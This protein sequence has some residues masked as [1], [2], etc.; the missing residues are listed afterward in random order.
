MPAAHDNYEI[1]KEAAQKYFLNFD[2]QSIIDI[3]H[4]QNDTQYLYVSFFETPYR[5]NRKNGAIEKSTD[6][7]VTA[8]AAGFQEVLSIFD[9][10]CHSR[11]R[12]QPSGNWAPVNSLKGRPRT[13]GV[14]TGLYESSSRIF[15]ADTAK[16]RAACEKSG[17]TPEKFGDIGYRFRVF[18][19][20][21]VILKFYQSD[22]EFPAQATILWDENTLDSIYYETAFYIAGF[23]LH[24]LEELC[25]N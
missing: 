4:L 19:S 5:I 7:F 16:F 1:Q 15:D 22:E 25:R 8:S 18:D 17:G 24:T 21:S 12:F 23:L 6:H 11:K 14:G 2:Q 10:L 9:L 3:F 20:M 13:I